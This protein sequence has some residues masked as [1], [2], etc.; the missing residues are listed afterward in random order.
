MIIKPGPRNLITDVK[1]ILVGNAEDDLSISGVTIVVPDSEL[2]LTELVGAVDVRGGAPGTRETEA[3]ALDTLVDVVHGVVLAGG[4][5]FGLAAASGLMDELAVQGRGFRL[6][7]ACVPIVPAAILFD[8]LNGGHKEAVGEQLY[9]QLGRLAYRQ[10][11][12]LFSL[13]NIGAGLGAKAGYFRNGRMIKGGLGSASMQ[14]FHDQQSSITNA[15]DCQSAEFSCGALVAVNSLG[16]A[17]IEDGPCFW[18]YP[19]E[20]DGE[21]GGNRPPP[22]FR[23]AEASWGEIPP[24]LSGQTSSIQNTTIGIIATDLELTKAEAKRIAMMAHDGLARALR[25]IHTLMDGD[26]LFVV[27]SRLVKKRNNLA[28]LTRLGMMAADCVA[29]AV[30]RGVF[31]GNPVGNMVRWDRS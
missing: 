19:W 2:G 24:P 22:G 4:S 25:P 9:S 8:L 28:D 14:A 7:K 5:A 23:L 10:T 29:R 13:G 26:S 3:L 12:R 27:S 1:G 20:W 18:A 11:K 16:S 17:L 30:A 21:F 6:G 31:H 15:K